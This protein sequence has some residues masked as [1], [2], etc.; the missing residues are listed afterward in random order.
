VDFGLSRP[1]HVSLTSPF[2]ELPDWEQQILIASLYRIEELMS[3]EDVDAA[4]IL[5]I[6]DVRPT[7][8]G[9]SGCVACSGG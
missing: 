2:G 6:G 4:P 7:G 1:V 5:D 8:A 3:A 9:E